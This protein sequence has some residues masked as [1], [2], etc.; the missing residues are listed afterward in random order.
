METI[1]FISCH[2]DLLGDPLLGEDAQQRFLPKYYTSKGTALDAR[3]MECTDMACPYCHLEIPSANVDL[4]SSVYS[5]VGAPASGTSYFLTTMIW[6]LRKSL[7]NTFHFNMYDSSPQLN[8]VLNNY[9]KT[10]FM[11]QMGKE[12]VSLPKTELRGANFSHQIKI[13]NVA[14]DLPRPFI[15]TLMPL[16]THPEYYSKKAFLNRGIVLYDN[17][18]E[19]F[20][21]GRDIH[22][23]LATLHLIHS[24]GIF[25]IYDPLKDIRMREM[26]S[27]DDPQISQNSECFNQYSIF[28]EMVARIRKNA[29]LKADEKYKRPLV[30]VVPKYDAWRDS[31]PLDLEKSKPV[32]YEDG[33]KPYLDM[34]MICNVSF[35]LR[36]LLLKFAPEFVGLAENLSEKVFFVPVSALGQMP[37]FD[38]GKG[39]IGIRPEHIKPIWADVPFLLQM[40]LN[41]LLPSAFVEDETIPQVENCSFLPHFIGFTFPGSDERFLVPSF[42]GGKAVFNADDQCYYRIPEAPVAGWREPDSPLNEGGGASGG[43]GKDLVNDR[44]FWEK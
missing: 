31:F 15:F 10:L 7:F 4:P 11:N 39:L 8:G 40:H 43:A 21:I 35:N 37:Q 41:Q 29:N 28:A 14:I 32:I 23:N 26:C 27:K 30:I 24:D 16:E 12:L 19:H 17:A 9:E 42:Y 5:I 25:F 1:L 36:R 13:D 38:E 44:R 3:G 20:E 22:T 6:E 18:G 2:P 34:G 33:S